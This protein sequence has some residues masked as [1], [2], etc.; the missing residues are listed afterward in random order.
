MT[1]LYSCLSWQSFTCQKG[2]DVKS[3]GK[4]KPLFT[5]A[6][7]PASPR[8]APVSP[9]DVPRSRPPP[10]RLVSSG[11][12]RAGR[13]PCPTRSARRG[14]GADLVHYTAPMVKL[15]KQHEILNNPSTCPLVSLA[16]D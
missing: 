16:V 14:A 12:G 4:I 8:L 6:P 5:R 10:Q 1:L 2:H 11:G 15:R 3:I 13:P 9:L 7:P